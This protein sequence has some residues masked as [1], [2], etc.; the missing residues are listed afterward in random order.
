V[1]PPVKSIV[2]VQPKIHHIL[3]KFMLYMN[4]GEGGCIFLCV[5]NVMW[6]GFVICPFFKTRFG[7]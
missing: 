2:K 6:T 3:G 4:W 7:M 5:V 1:F